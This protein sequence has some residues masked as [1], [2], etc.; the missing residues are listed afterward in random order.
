MLT[1]IT[2]KNL[3]IVDSLE[4]DFESGFSVLTGETGA[5]KSIL[6]DALCLVLGDRADSSLVRKGAQRADITACFELHKE[7]PVRHWLK[8]NDLQDDNESSLCI[9]RRSVNQNGRSK[10]YINGQMV[11]LQL[12]REIGEQLINIHGQN[13]HQLLL[14][15]K[16]QRFLLDDHAQL[17]HITHELNSLYSQWQQ[18]TSE[19]EH[20]NKQQ[21][22][23]L[24]QIE[25]LTYQLAELEQFAPFE[26]EI[27]E[28]EE[29]YKKLSHANE[30]IDQ[31]NTISALLSE[32]DSFEGKSFSV[33]QL[34]ST[35]NRGLE[36]LVGY[37][38]SLLEI[39]ELLNQAFV[40]VQEAASGIRQY[41]SV[42]DVHPERLAELTERI[43]SYY[44][45]SRKHQCEP[46]AL[47]ETLQKIKKDVLKL[48]NSDSYLDELQ[49]QINNLY[50]DYFDLAKQLSVGRKLAAAELAIQ[51]EKH[52]HDLGMDQAKFSIILKPVED[53]S[54]PLKDG[55]EKIHYMVSTNPG[56]SSGLISKIASGGELSRIS[57]AI[58]VVTAQYSSIPTLIFD[59][60][61]VGVGG[62]IAEMIG[63][64]L[65]LLAQQAQILCVTHQAQLAAHGDQHYLVEKNTQNQQ[66]VSTIDALKTR[67]R[68]EE[69]SRMLGSANITKTT[70]RHAKEM[71]QQAQ[72]Q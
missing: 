20:L 25:L 62:K 36:E 5:G 16:T 51:V 12:L 30:I 55:L 45:L 43:S 48:E 37:D 17:N 49:L 65:H 28:L 18:K 42:S 41:L 57:L 64:K 58:Q 11:P 14:N 35:S 22:D 70:R 32:S 50:T 61:D 26:Q 44:D 29:E 47:Y 56:Q 9:L 7:K 4:L 53:P 54:L 38:E 66:T 19:F 33:E 52:I 72:N 46:A 27:K 39:N 67:Q 24:Q 3:A 1:Q 68:I 13:S 63:V 6:I 31:L 15:H 23:R 60:V 59:E 40:Q 34:L 71:F 69:M 21:H 8:Q 2:V 10:G